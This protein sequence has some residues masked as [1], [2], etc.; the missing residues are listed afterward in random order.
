VLCMQYLHLRRLADNP[1]W[2]GALKRRV[3]REV[4]EQGALINSL[5]VEPELGSPS[6]GG[7]PDTLARRVGD[8]WQLS[9]HKLY[10]TGI[11]GL[12]WL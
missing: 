10:T 3:A 11:P 1:D 4:L 2:P 5:R 6:R 7:L 9:G 8:G 12:T